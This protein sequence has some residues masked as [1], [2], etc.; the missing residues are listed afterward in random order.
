EVLDELTDL[1]RLERLGRL[2]MVGDARGRPDR[3]L[4]PRTAVHATVV[5]ELEKGEGAPSPDRRGHAG[6]VR[7]GGLVPRDRIV[8]HLGGG[9]RVELGVSGD[10][11]GRG[12]GGALPEVAA[13]ALA[14]EA[15]LAPRAA[16]LGEHR[17]V[18]AADD[19]V[20]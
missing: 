2:E 11:D 16:R 20:A 18:G 8:E 10:D 9:G 6:E 13:V 15:R 17:E 1:V 5:R 7:N 4:R 3:Q 19:A 14:E 12:G